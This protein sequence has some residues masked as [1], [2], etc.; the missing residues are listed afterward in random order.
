MIRAIFFISSQI[1]TQGKDTLSRGNVYH[2]N[3]LWR[4]KDAL[5]TLDTRSAERRELLGEILRIAELHD[6]AEK[7]I[8]RSAPVF[9]FLFAIFARTNKSI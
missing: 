8:R 9:S 3:T 2:Q 4:A 7:F 6:R 1:I 5:N